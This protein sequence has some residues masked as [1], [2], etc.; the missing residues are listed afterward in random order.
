MKG[1]TNHKP[2]GG[3]GLWVIALESHECVH[4]A[5]I[6][7]SRKLREKCVSMSFMHV[8]YNSLNSEPEIEDML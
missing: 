5:L 3:K 7:L 6:F 8:L 1:K 4:E 2:Q